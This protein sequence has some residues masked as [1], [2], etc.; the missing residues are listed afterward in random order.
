[1]LLDIDV[2]LVKAILE[3]GMVKF[4]DSGITVNHLQ[5]GGR[6]AFEFL[7]D[8]WVQYKAVPS[9]GTIFAET[10]IDVSKSI[11]EPLSYFVE[12]IKKRALYNELNHLMSKAYDSLKDVKPEDALN[13]LQSG[14]FS[15]QNNVPVGKLTEPFFA[16]Y[17][18]LI[19]EY[20][21]AEQYGIIGIPSGWPSLDKVTMGWQKE[22]LVLFAARPGNGKTWILLILGL[23]AWLLHQKKVLFVS[24]EMGRNA[25]RRR[26]MSYIAEI[27]YTGIRQANLKSEH[28]S[29]YFNKLRE[30]ATDDRLLI[31][32]K[33]MKTSIA[34]LEAAIMLHEPDLVC[35][36]GFYLITPT[37]NARDKHERIANLFDD[38]KDLA[39]R[40]RVPFLVTSQINRAGKATTAEEFMDLTRLSFSDNAG[41]VSDYVFFLSKEEDGK[42]MKLMPG[43]T[44]ESD[45]FRPIVIN[46]DF[47][48]HDF[49]EPGHKEF[50]GGDI[51]DEVPGDIPH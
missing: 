41:M 7:W 24:T 38:G 21:K 14:I 5:G 10:G 34:A 50:V 32:G 35:I 9:A 19:E 8:F 31:F 45:L 22:D 42:Q 26:A 28:K 23:R 27:S 37:R 11:D 4:N 12:Q 49:S 6:K 3:E 2:G 29:L 43:K 25:L 16:D 47:R 36:D 48:N 30:M 39:T 1:M 44:R 15:L 13:V 17:E 51:P 33:G 20:E 46:W 18:G 40:H